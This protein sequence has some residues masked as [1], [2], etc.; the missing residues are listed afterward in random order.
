MKARELFLFI[1]LLILGFWTLVPNQSFAEQYPDRPIEIVIPNAAGSSMDIGAR[2]IGAELE[3]ILHTKIIP[4]NRPG[5]GTVL[6]TEA[7]IRAKK[8]GYTLLYGDFCSA[9]IIAPIVNPKI[10]HYDPFKDVEPLGFHFFFPNII[11]V[12]SDSPW[13]TFSELIDHVKKNP[14]KV[15]F[16]TMGTNTLPHLVLEMIQDITGTQFIHVP[17]AGGE[18]LMVGV[19]GGHVEVTCVS[20]FLVKPHVDAQKARMLLITNKTHAFPEIPTI[21]ELGYKQ[22]LPSPGFGLYA[23]AGIPA[24]VKNILVLAMEKAVKNTKQKVE[25]T[26]LWGVCEYK[27][28]LELRK[29]WE[30]EYQKIY[31][32]ATKAGLRKP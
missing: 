26:P 23:P 25:Q 22:S 17:F 8:D 5:A 21:T 15:R 31:E 16:C 11:T 1:V 3:K 18:S 28:P 24:E 30:E 19:L 29:M 27:S 12:R 4:T 2:M 32:I 9:L 13:K 6:G 10:V 20:P 14:K 7:V